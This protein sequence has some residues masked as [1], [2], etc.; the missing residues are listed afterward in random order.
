MLTPARIVKLLCLF[1]LVSEF[2]V[3][4]SGLTDFPLY[5]VD[6]EIGYLPAPNQQGSFLHKHSW[7]YNDRSMGVASAW[8]P[9]GHTNILLI[10]NSIVSG[11]N[12]FDQKE[13]LGPLIQETIGDTYALWPISAGGWT[14]IN[15]IVYLNRNPDVAKS[16]QFF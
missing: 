3:R 12:P 4:A 10:G 7:A 13:K 6:S 1:F 5:N 9:A 11:G 15:E 8:N 16:A 2:A 14:N